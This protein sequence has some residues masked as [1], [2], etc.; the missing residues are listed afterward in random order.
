VRPATDPFSATGGLKLLTGNLG[1]S[2]IKVSAVPQ[3][4][5]VIE[6]PARIFNAQKNC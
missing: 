4:R 6:A 2:V 3:D 1:R 5:H